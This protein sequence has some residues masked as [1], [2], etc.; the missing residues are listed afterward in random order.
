MTNNT[1]ELKNYVLKYV[2]NITC[3]LVLILKKVTWTNE[4]ESTYDVNKYSVSH[5]LEH[6]KN[7]G[8][9]L[10]KPLSEVDNVLFNAVITPNPKSFYDKRESIR[11]YTLNPD[12]ED[13]IKEI[14]DEIFRLSNTRTDLKILIDE[15][16]KKTKIHRD[17]VLDNIKKEQNNY[18]I[19]NYMPDG[20]LFYVQSQR[21]KEL[22]N[23]TKKIL[24]E[25][26]LEKLREK[27]KQ[28]LLSLEQKN[29]LMFL[30]SNPLIIPV[31]N[32]PKNS[33]YTGI[34]SNH[35]PEELSK[36]ITGIT[37]EEEEQ[38]ELEYKMQKR[39]QLDELWAKLKDEDNKYYPKICIKDK[40]L[41]ELGIATRQELKN[42][43]KTGDT[44]LDFL[45]TLK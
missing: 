41:K 7:K 43:K 4:L 25:I 22:E 37:L 28:G 8:L 9:I 20:T 29:E 31:T 17:L 14:S 13:I 19:K 11:V 30:K 45:N 35:S 23:E 39:K 12:Y 18:L 1:E 42:I 38:V 15:I 36:I 40:G 21:S 2:S 33:T 5:F 16:L 27:E 24:K 44:G 10:Y 6:L 32:K 26:K 34:Y 3:F